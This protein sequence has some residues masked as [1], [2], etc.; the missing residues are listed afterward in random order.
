MSMNILIALAAVTQSITPGLV[1]QEP[2]A[3][4]RVQFV[5]EAVCDTMRLRIENFGLTYSRDAVPT[6]TLNGHRL[7]GDQAA[8]LERD[9]ADQRAVYRFS[10][11]CPQN[12]HQIQLE[13]YSG[14]AAD[15]GPEFR[16]GRAFF[17]DDALSTYEPLEPARSLDFWFS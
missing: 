12:S 6:V 11:R 4:S 14:K 8:A 10:T 1:V 9:L 5:Y 2:R 17:H 13:I 3:P 15:G 16:S 7:R